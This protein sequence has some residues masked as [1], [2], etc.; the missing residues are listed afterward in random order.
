MMHCVIVTFRLRALGGTG[1][2][3]LGG[4]MTLTVEG[5]QG[6]M[7]RGLSFIIPFLLVVYALELYNAYILYHLSYHPMS[8]EWQVSSHAITYDDVICFYHLSF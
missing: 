2:S 3:K 4:Q 7:W 5:F 1:T 8:Y 6:W